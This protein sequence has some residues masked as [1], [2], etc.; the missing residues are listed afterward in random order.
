[1]DKSIITF[2]SHNVNGFFRSKDFIK[3]QCESNLNSIRAIQEHWLRPPYKKLHGVNQLRNV[4]P[5]FDGYG[6]LA[7]SKASDS[8]VI[9]GRPFGG[10]GFIF[11]KKYAKCLKPLIGVNHERVTALEQLKF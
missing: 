11:N 3:S 7:M 5:C 4:H 10:T 6:T 2:V 1:M 8:K 9:T